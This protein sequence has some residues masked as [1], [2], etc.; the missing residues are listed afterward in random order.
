MDTH[1]NAPLT[2]KGREEFNFSIFFGLPSRDPKPVPHSWIDTRPLENGDGP[3]PV[4]PIAPRFTFVHT[5][6]P[7]AGGERRALLQACQ[8]SNRL[9]KIWFLRSK[10]IV[11]ALWL[12]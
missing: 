3:S 2:P 4:P 8:H 9:T 10:E 1:K 7:G 11:D 12:W 6:K 5:T